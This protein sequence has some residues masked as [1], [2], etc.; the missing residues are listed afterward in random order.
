MA[1]QNDSTPSTTDQKIP[2]YSRGPIVARCDPWYRIKQSV[3]VIICLGAGLWCLYDGFY[4]FPKENAQW[5]PAHGVKPPHGPYDAPLNKALGLVLPPLG[6][7]FL[8]RMLRSTRGE[9]RLDGD[10]LHVPGHPPIP[11]SSIRLIDKAIWER[12]GI[13]RIEYELGES[14]QRNSFKL[15]DIAYLREPTDQILDRI[16]AYAASVAAAAS[17]TS[18]TSTSA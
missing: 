11:L 6:I 9:Y 13:A 4:R 7:F 8:V 5:N 2:D 14:G 17:A 12:K 16:E 18:D 15:D 1:D 3:V 10:T